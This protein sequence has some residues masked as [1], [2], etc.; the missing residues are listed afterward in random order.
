MPSTAS[1]VMEMEP[2]DDRIQTH[3]RAQEPVFRKP[4]NILLVEDNANDATLT[5][6]AL[7]FLRSIMIY[8]DWIAA[9][10][11]CLSLPP[12]KYKDEQK[13]DMLLLDL[14]LPSKGWFWGTGGN[15]V[16]VRALWRYSR[17]DPDR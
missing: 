3:L 6:I 14:S 7:D 17:S 12:G 4:V 11:Y 16:A 13:P 8:I 1:N 9:R 5:Q 2:C 10:T 15:G